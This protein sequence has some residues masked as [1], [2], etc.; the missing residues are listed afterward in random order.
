MDSR[1]KVLLSVQR[2]LLGEVTPELRGLSVEVNDT[3][4]RLTSYFAGRLTAEQKDTVSTIT[5]EVAADLPHD[6]TIEDEAVSLPESERLPEIA[7]W[8]Y[9]RK[10]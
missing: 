1:A 7:I 3:H 5:A 9:R 8:A 10:E 4:V 2:A 6:W